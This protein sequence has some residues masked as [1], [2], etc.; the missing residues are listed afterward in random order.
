VSREARA[1]FERTIVPRDL[2]QYRITRDGVEKVEDGSLGG[3]R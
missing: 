1:I 3:G 2:D